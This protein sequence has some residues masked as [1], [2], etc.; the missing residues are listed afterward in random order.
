MIR[1]AVASTT[2]KKEDQE[3]Q[4]EER[5]KVPGE[6]VDAAAVVEPGRR[7]EGETVGRPEQRV[8]RNELIRLHV[9]LHEPLL[10]RSVLEHLFLAAAFGASLL[11][12]LRGDVDDDREIRT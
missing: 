3:R 5:R 12:D 9:E 10:E 11:R 6:L 7:A 4:V 8:A 2:L 1:A